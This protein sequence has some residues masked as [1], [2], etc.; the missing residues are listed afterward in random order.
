MA[1][2][3]TELT[4]GTWGLVKTVRALD[5]NE[6]GLVGLD[7]A[8]GDVEV[9]DVVFVILIFMFFYFETCFDL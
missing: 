3:A 8:L 5:S 4:C 7:L 2:W 1:K 6:V 9:E